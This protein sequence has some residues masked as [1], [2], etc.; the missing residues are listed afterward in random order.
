MLDFRK[1]MERLQLLSEAL[2]KGSQQVANNPKLV[3]DLADAIREDSR[4]N[5]QSFPDRFYREARKKSDEE[6]AEWFLKNLDDIE[7]QGYEGATYSR[8]GVNSRWLVA[9]YINRAHN[10]EDIV[11]TANMG[12]SQWYYLK[13][14]DLLDSNHQDLQ[15]FNGVR[16]LNKYMVF[17][18]T[19]K[20]REHQERMRE[21]LMKKGAKA[22]KLIDNQDYRIYI[23]LNRWGACA[24]G[25]GANWCTANTT[26]ADLWHRYS[27]AGM[28]YQLYP[29]EPEQISKQKY[30]KVFS[31]PERYQFD[32]PSGSFMDIADDPV[33]KD[34]KPNIIQEKY[35]YLLDD[36]VTALTQKKAEIENVFKVLGNDPKLQDHNTTK[37]KIYDVDQEIQKLKSPGIAAYFTDKKRPNEQSP[38][39]ELT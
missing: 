3:A 5:P 1:L 25:K 16:D 18:Y 21:V 2:T 12:L 17:H 22:F 31:G 29:K 9:K 26:S 35:P 32:A 13:N 37:V 39:A 14:R 7:A 4:F 23:M 38:T 6:L 8:D 33:G 15:S 36:L 20:L 28:I 34:K 24:Y 11:G 19:E 10:W 30:G 27:N